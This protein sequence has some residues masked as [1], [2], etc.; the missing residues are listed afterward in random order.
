MSIG[1]IVGKKM[2]LLGHCA[3]HLLLRLNSRCHRISVSDF[4]RSDSRPLSQ[5]CRR[6]TDC[7]AAAASCAGLRMLTY[8][9]PLCGQSPRRSAKRDR[10][11]AFKPK[12]RLNAPCL[13]RFAC[14]DFTV[15]G[16]G[17]SWAIC[18]SAP[19]LRQY[20]HTHTQPFYCSAGICPGLP[21]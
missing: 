2:K 6:P 15:S 9:N 10:H 21:G 12:L 16:I 4:G 8:S 17:I 20:T 14:L 5:P 3:T 1:V 13:S 18:K 19:R 11:G 7:M